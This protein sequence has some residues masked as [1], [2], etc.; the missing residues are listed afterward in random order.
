[1]SI[2][3]RTK[4]SITLGELLPAWAQELAGDRASIDRVKHELAERLLED[5]IYGRLDDKGPV[6]KSGEC[7]GLRFIK[8]NGMAIDIRGHQ[9]LSLLT[10]AT[11]SF[12]HICHRLVVMKEGV[13]D[14]SRRRELPRPSW[15]AS[16]V[17]QPVSS[18][19]A[20][21]TNASDW[22]R[23]APASV[24]R[25][26]IRDVYDAKKAAAEKPP[27]IKELPAPVLAILKQQ[28]YTASARRIQELGGAAKFRKHRRPPGTTVRSERSR[29]V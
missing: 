29:Q 24:I 14:F 26:A 28:R 27:N 25:K 8:S 9:V 4:R 18:D 22:A 20:T 5:I 23:P 7:V 11:S 21:K 17:N 16:E 15:W 12:E 10:R 3:Y 13:V 1:M 19:R 6:A 2:L